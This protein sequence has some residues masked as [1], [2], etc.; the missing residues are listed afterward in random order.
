MSPRPWLGAV[1]DAVCVSGAERKVS[2]RKKNTAFEIR[3]GE[4]REGEIE[5]GGGGV[6]GGSWGSGRGRMGRG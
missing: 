6:R 5:G 2:I 1:H 4:S 3:H